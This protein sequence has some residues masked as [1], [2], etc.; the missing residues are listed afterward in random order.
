MYIMCEGIDLYIFV[1]TRNTNSNNKGNTDAWKLFLNTFNFGNRIFNNTDEEMTWL[2]IF[3]WLKT[4]L[5]RN[6]VLAVI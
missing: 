3:N 4:L 5:E 2:I 1:Q 6:S